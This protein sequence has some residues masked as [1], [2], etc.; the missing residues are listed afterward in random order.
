M[1]KLTLIGA[2]LLAMVPAAAM[3]KDCDA[4]KAEVKQQLKEAKADNDKKRIADLE[5]SMAKL[6]DCKEEAHDKAKKKTD[7]K[8][9]EVNERQRDLDKAKASGDQDD[10]KKRED[11]LKDSKKE[12]NKRLEDEREK[13]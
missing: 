2:L 10:V 8:R 6:S 7:K 1:K 3:A 13:R 11:K 5:K 9:D 12:L 4:R